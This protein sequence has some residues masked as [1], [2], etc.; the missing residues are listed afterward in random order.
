MAGSQGDK[1]ALA[2]LVRRRRFFVRT[3][4]EKLLGFLA[5]DGLWRLIK[6]VAP[7]AEYVQI[8][9]KKDALSALLLDEEARLLASLG[10]ALDVHVVQEHDESESKEGSCEDNPNEVLR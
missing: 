10:P 8:D 3:S 7:G 6:E 5:L 2:A 1:V 9:V 4:K